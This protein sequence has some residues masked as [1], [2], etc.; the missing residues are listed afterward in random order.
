MSARRQSIVM[1][2]TFMSRGASDAASWPESSALLAG[3]ASTE[4]ACGSAG[5]GGPADMPSREHGP[6]VMPAT[7]ASPSVASCDPAWRTRLRVY[8]DE[9]LLPDGHVRRAH[10]EQDE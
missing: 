4:E 1:S 6:T 8:G 10:A 2:R 3:R 9:E 5:W 7:S